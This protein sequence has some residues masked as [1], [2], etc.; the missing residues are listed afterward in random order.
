MVKRKIIFSI[1]SLFL[2]LALLAPNFTFAHP[3]RTDSSGCHTCRTNCPNWG[4]SYGEYH[5]HRAKTLPQPL[6]PI[7]RPRGIDGGSGYVSPAPEYKTPSNTLK[8]TE[9]VKVASETNINA[10]KKSWVIKLFTWLF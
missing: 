7:K 9:N 4:L 10:E 6:E 8:K 5:C 2:A 1:V 3:G